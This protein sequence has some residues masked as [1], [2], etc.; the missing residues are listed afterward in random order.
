MHYSAR[1]RSPHWHCK[2]KSKQK[3]VPRVIIFIIAGITYSEMR[4][5][6]EVTAAAKNC[7]VIVGKYTKCII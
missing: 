6:C 1:Y 2:D 3:N 4:S 5:A 7:E